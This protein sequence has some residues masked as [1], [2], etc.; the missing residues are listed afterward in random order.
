MDKWFES[1]LM[2]IGK[3][4]CYIKPVKSKGLKLDA[5][6]NLVL[7]KDFIKKIAIK[8]I[9][10]EDLRKYPLQQLDNF[11]LQLSKYTKI[12]KKNLAIGNGSDQIIDLILSAFGKEK[13]VT[14]FTPTFSYFIDRCQLY[15]MKIDKI[16]LLQDNSIDKKK[17]IQ[18]AKKS[19]IIYI[20]SPNNPTG[21]QFDKELLIDIFKNLDDKLIILDE[22]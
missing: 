7:K 16:P 4:N 13:R 3:L 9:Q 18:S 14:T 11:Y 6:E 8:A 22:A 15:S 1:K 12:D 20:C 19:E 5:N 21:N 2:E 10:K 17:F